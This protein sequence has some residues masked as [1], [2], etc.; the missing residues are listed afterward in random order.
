M[1]DGCGRVLLHFIQFNSCE[2]SDFLQLNHVL[3]GIQRRCCC[4]RCLFCH[5]V[6]IHLNGISGV[7]TVVVVGTNNTHRVRNALI[8]QLIFFPCRRLQHTVTNHR[9]SVSTM[10]V[11]WW[12]GVMNQPHNNLE[13]SVIGIAQKIFGFNFNFYFRSI[14]LHY[15][16]EWATFG[17]STMNRMRRFTFINRK[18]RELLQ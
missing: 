10:C 17:N 11:H 18:Y 13:I 5:C 3:F 16:F 14:L 9:I 8:C 7:A 2:W 6:V 12:R 1:N 4:S 15:L